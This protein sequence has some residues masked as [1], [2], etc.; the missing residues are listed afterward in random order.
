MAAIAATKAVSTRRQRIALPDIAKVFR[1]AAL[2]ATIRAEREAW[3]KPHRP[4][5]ELPLVG[6]T[7]VYYRALLDLLLLRG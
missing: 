4:D 7:R 5:E 2:P 3:R 1:F 6:A